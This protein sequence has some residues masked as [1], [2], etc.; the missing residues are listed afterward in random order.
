MSDIALGTWPFAGDAIWGRSEESA[1][2]RVVH[3]ALDAGITLFDT[4]PNYGAGRCDQ[5]LGKAL[6]GRPEALVATKTKIDRTD[7]HALRESVTASLR[8]LGRDSIDILQIHW[9]GSTPEQTQAALEV[10]VALRDE[11]LVRFVGVCN[12]GRYDLDETQHTQ[13]VSNQL[14]YSL[15]W[16]VIEAE[17]APASRARGLT[18][19]AYSPLQQGL[20]GGAYRS[21]AQFPQGRKRTRHFAAQWPATQHDEAGMEAQTDHAL[22]QLY[23]LADQTGLSLL[24]LALAF[25]RSRAFIDVLLIGAKTEQQLRQSCHAAGT[26]LTP[27][28]VAAAERATE[29]LRQAAGGNPD[30]YQSASRVRYSVPDA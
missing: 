28:E 16:R 10:F 25:V 3:A 1:C 17:I 22:Q 14:P 30:M 29:Q 18:T 19:I 6:R 9:P 5:I 7:K 4:A 8:R 13:L 15:L 11:G 27:H 26:R 23:D 12:F 2:I 24:E 21:T 20:L